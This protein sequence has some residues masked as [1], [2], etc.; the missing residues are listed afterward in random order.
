MVARLAL[1]RLAL[2][3]LCVLA[4]AARAQP[5]AEAPA[6]QRF[7]TREGLS[8]ENVFS[9]LQDRVGFLWVGTRDGLNRYDGHSFRTYRRSAGIPGNEVA[10]LAE[11]DDGLLW[12]GTERG[13]VTMNRVTGRVTPVRLPGA[14]G[15]AVTAIRPDARGGLWIGT[16]RRGLYY[17][18][19]NGAWRLVPLTA[20]PKANRRAGVVSVS[21]GPGGDV[22]AGGRPRPDRP[23]RARPLGPRTDRDVR[24]RDPARRHGRERRRAVRRR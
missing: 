14:D 1:A 11:T 5:G 15:A 16:D 18:P 8:N 24:R 2:L 4:A 17:R 20:D 23:H 21:S 13:A 10:A 6:F 22:G 9:L 12:I 3:A 19:P 7:G